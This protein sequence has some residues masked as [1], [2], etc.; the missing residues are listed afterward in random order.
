MEQA[1]ERPL[2]RRAQPMVGTQQQ[3]RRAIRHVRR[4]CTTGPCEEMMPR[5]TTAR[6]DDQPAAERTVDEAEH[7]RRCASYPRG[8]LEQGPSPRGQG[9]D[10]QE[11]QGN[12]LYSLS[13][14]YS[15]FN[16][17]S[18]FHPHVYSLW[19]IYSTARS[20]P[21]S[22]RPRRSTRR[23]HGRWLPRRSSPALPDD[24]A[25]CRCAGSAPEMADMPRGTAT[26]DLRLSRGRHS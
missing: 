7:G 25:A 15:N 6:A 5:I 17:F 10:H 26:I 21:F 3:G 9:Y 20:H 2:R 4:A 23:P 22:A 1:L 11:G 8:R 24:A 12:F 16:I 19:L 18:A 13:L 14:G